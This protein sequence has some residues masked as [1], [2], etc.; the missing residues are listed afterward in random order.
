MTKLLPCPFCDGKARFIPRSKSSDPIDH[1]HWAYVECDEC[2]ASTC[3]GKTDEEAIAA[4][5]RRVPLECEA[6]CP[7]NIG[8]RHDEE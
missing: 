4:W 1:Y 3:F 5:N 6:T 8:R 2:S 7:L